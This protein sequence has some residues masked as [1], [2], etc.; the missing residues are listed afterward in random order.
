MDLLGDTL[1]VRLQ[2]R[3]DVVHVFSSVCNLP[4]EGVFNR[5]NLVDSLCQRVLGEG[6]EGLTEGLYVFVCAD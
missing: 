4:V 2:V 5:F 1:E 3:G 6:R